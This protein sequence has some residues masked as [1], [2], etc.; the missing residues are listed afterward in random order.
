M[1]K[2]FTLYSVWSIILIFKVIDSDRR[3]ESLKMGNDFI[4]EKGAEVLNFKYELTNFIII[5]YYNL[6]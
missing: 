6:L 1:T 5:V 4:M 2:I 3:R